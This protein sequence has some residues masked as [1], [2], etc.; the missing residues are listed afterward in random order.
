MAYIHYN[1]GRYVPPT[2]NVY[3]YYYYFREPCGI[4]VVLYVVRHAYKRLY[5]ILYN[6][7]KV[8]SGERR[9][10][11]SPSVV[12]SPGDLFFFLS[13]SSRPLFEFPM[14]LAGGMAVKIKHICDK[15]KK[16]K[17]EKV[18]VQYRDSM[19]RAVKKTVYSKGRARDEMI[20]YII[21]IYTLR[22]PY[23]II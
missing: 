4:L 2:Y 3:Y 12:M 22:G 13:L 10:D 8:R 16:R 9:F 11:V 14:T 18:D 7:F 20:E 17:R 19:R 5:N 21:I 6:I 1:I 23:V 15:K